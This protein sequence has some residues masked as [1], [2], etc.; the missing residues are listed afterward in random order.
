MQH[1]IF[2][3]FNRLCPGGSDCKCSSGSHF[4]NLEEI[5]SKEWGS[6]YAVMWEILKIH[7]KTVPEAIQK[8]FDSLYEV[9]SYLFE[10]PWFRRVWVLQEALNAPRA[11]LRCGYNVLPWETLI[12][13]N[14][15]FRKQNGYGEAYRE[16]M[17]R[18]PS[19]WARLAGAGQEKQSTDDT[20]KSLEI[21]RP[22]MK[23]LDVFLEGLE[24]NSTDPRD[25]L[26]ALLGFA[27]ETS[28]LYSLPPA[29]RPNYGKP[30][31][32]VFAD[33]TRWWITEHKSLHILSAVHG[34]P[35]RTWQSLHCPQC[36]REGVICPTW[37]VGSEGTS[38]G[39]KITLANLFEYKASSNT[40]PDLDLLRDSQDPLQ[41]RL[42][43]VRLTKIED[44]ASFPFCENR[45]DI[46]DLFAPYINMFDP[47]STLA[48]WTG[49]KHD[50][51]REEAVTP[52]RMHARDHWM[53][54]WG[55]EPR[56]PLSSIALRPF[57]VEPE[58][59]EQLA[60]E[61]PSPS[62]NSTSLTKNPM[63][64]YHPGRYDTRFGLPCHDPCF[65]VTSDGLVGLCPSAARKGD[66]I[67]ILYGGAVPF[68]LREIEP[69][70]T[71]PICC[72]EFIGECFL[73][74]RMDGR[75]IEE[76]RRLKV[77]PEVF[78]LL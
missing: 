20:S 63:E 12:E 56:P 2:N 75:I 31:N 42:L 11:F 44:I 25:K 37:A 23:I 5:T 17:T 49:L 18:M 33:F 7:L 47:A 27:E 60:S 67:V 10:H 54:H 76:Q 59:S 68:L 1:D 71:R 43:G 52:N 55:Y 13:V 64:R 39:S 62:S 3:Y 73:K 14:Q 36:E 34:N 32:E 19:L 28:D 61:Q 24:L 16:P 65:F 69:D 46:S 58:T 41:L 21:S 51:V 48:A 53:A 50:I 72:Y 70:Q 66:L 6:E 40:C 30:T 38:N 35:G 15:F 77:A 57:G 22:R 29:I 4:V 74:D 9:M 26:F 78:T 8:R 45:Q